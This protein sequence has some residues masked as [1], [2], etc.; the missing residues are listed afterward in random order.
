MSGHPG[1]IL[2]IISTL[3][4]L[5]IVCVGYSS[6]QAALIVTL[7][8]PDTSGFP[9]LIAY[10]DVHDPT[11]G[12]VHG[13]TP[14]DVTLQ[15]NGV[16]VPVTGLEEQKPGVQL[17]IAIAPGASFTIRDTLGISR[18]EY[19]LQGL[20]AGTWASQPSV[21]DD[22]SLLT[23][24][25]PQLTH[26]SNPVSLQSSLEAYKPDDPHAIPSLEVLASALQVA[27]DPTTRP[28]MERAVLFITSPQNANV[29][30]GLQ[31]IIAS[32]SQQNIHIFVWLVAAPEVLSLPE[33]DQL[34]N[35]ADQTH[36]AFFAFSHDETVP[37]LETLLEPL[38]YIYQLSYDTKVSKTGPQ[39]VAAQL[40]VGSEVI[41]SPAKSFDVN[42][43]SPL[44]TLL[45]PPVEITRTITSQPTSGKTDINGIL[46]PVE[47]VLNIQVTFPDGYKRPIILTRLYVDGA[48]VAENT[49]PPYDKFIWDLRPYTQAGLHTLSVEA[50]DN[51]GL[52]GVSGKASVRIIVPTTSQGM[53]VVVTQKRPLVIGVTVIVS[54]SILV[55]VL[56]V[57][58]RI[59]PKPHPGQVTHSTG[60]SEKTRPTGH[61][62]RMRQSKDPVT[63]PVK[64][65]VS[66]PV[67]GK[68][69][70]KS[71]RERLPWLK[72]TNEPISAMAYLI[73]LVGSDEPTLPAPLQVI[74]EDMTLG[75]DPHQSSLVIADP[76]IEGVH[77][78]IH[79]V[80]KS[81][82]ITDIGSVAGTW[83]N[84][85]KV[86]PQGTFL[87]HMD[88]IHLGRIGFRFKL[89]EPGRLRK[90]V[91]TPMEQKQ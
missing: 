29:S 52:V 28:G 3:L 59:H 81:F 79:H 30:L 2:P 60:S 24:G 14:Q 25:G 45:I 34:R 64:I 80:D 41:T 46:Q 71:W 10:L 82:L 69:P 11:G 31:S 43:Q 9:H 47:Q 61:R 16:S 13:L 20:L 22:F 90:V 88:I 27:L 18:Y 87:E 56:I 66:S 42:L 70:L 23:M 1:R 37:D 8:T 65:A 78:R 89:T 57:G 6:A 12:F 54:A 75:S 36:A 4:V 77:A 55:L 73:P 91:V 58:G 17:V 74:D 51:L 40:T 19:L 67:R 86:T 38:R 53:I 83:V 50:T 48:I 39:K 49:S 35:L 68:A 26:S 7:T 15:E 63:Q 76:S 62:E 72:R 5:F 33:I 21:V 32:A 84:Y 44:P 85:V